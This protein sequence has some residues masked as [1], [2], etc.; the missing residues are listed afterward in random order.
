MRIPDRRDAELNEVRWWSRWATLRWQGEGYLLSSGELN[1]PFFNRSG[2]LTCGAVLATTAWAERALFSAGLDST[3]LVFD[4]CSAAKKLI[5]SGYLQTDNMTV[6][7]SGRPPRGGGPEIGVRTTKDSEDW[8]SVYLRSFYGDERLRDVIR[9]II[10]PLVNLRVVTLLESRMRG[11]T[12]GVLALFRTPGILGVYCVGTVPEF[13][14][15]GVATALLGRAGQIAS[16]EGRSLILQ[17][18]M[19]DGALQFYLRRGFKAMY[20][21]LVLTRKLK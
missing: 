8:T 16:E 13:R 5:M 7:G 17:T 3:L 1:E 6:L 21:K 2:A 20:S 10:S 18:L 11:E 4:S 14:K 15:R 9:P 19:S 12:A